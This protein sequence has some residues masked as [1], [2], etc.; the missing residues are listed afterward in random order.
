MTKK[1]HYFLSFLLVLCNVVADTS[2]ISAA[3]PSVV[4][5]HVLV[6][7]DGAAT[8]EF[9]G[10]YN[11]ST[12]DVELTDYC[13]ENKSDVKFACIDGGPGTK[14]FIKAQEYLTIS[15]A[16]YSAKHAYHPDTVYEVT[17]KTSGSIVASSDT[18]ALMNPSGT[19]VDTVSWSGG[20]VTGSA[21]VRKESVYGSRILLDT[22]NLSDFVA[23]PDVAFPL[24]TSYDVEPEADVCSNLDGPQAE[25]PADYRFEGTECVLDLLPLQITE[26]LP[27]ATGS[28]TG[29]EFIELYNPTDRIAN[30]DI[31]RLYVGMSDPKI[32]S[33]PAGSSIGPGEYAVFYDTQI[34]FTLVNTTGKV[35]VAGSDNT[36]VSETEA[37]AQ[38]ADD[39]AWAL[40]GDTW[41]YTN[42]PTPGAGNNVS[43]E[44]EEGTSAALSPTPCPE[45]KYR[46]PL[47]GRCRTIESDAS[48]LATCDGDQYRNP[49]TGR[50]RK[51]TTPVSTAPCK[52]GQYRSEE[53]NRCRTIAAASAALAA[54]KDGQERNPETNRCRNVTAAAMPAAGFAV[55]PVAQGAQAFVG[56]WALGAVGFLA[57]GYAAW[58]W[59]AEIARQIRKIA[60]AIKIK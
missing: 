8:S 41:Q 10:L 18:I 25:L 16:G 54:C 60:T 28:D 7:E 5:S 31:Y 14:V 15:S 46:N 4:I 12:Q 21:W 27:N 36:V 20:L 51:L 22:D 6:G 19:E 40:I 53:T 43:I 30:L 3:S 33:F 9:I 56:W 26:V 17:N 34:Q 35:S 50:C 1:L 38:P 49:E 48:V 55:E 13:L 29:K 24:N 42:Q 59:R 58:E 2:N 45:G 47:T 11:N 23:H 44:V 39:E 57:L 32:Y 37:Y 52:E